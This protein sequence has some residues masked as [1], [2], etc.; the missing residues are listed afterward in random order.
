MLTRREFAVAIGAS[1]ALATLPAVAAEND[2]IK[3]GERNV[4]WAVDTDIIPVGAGMGSFDHIQLRVRGNGLFVYDLDV[5][6]GNGGNDDIPLQFHIP[7][8]GMTRMIDLRG[9]NRNIRH[10]KLTYQKPVDGG[11]PTW[12]ELWGQR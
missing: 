3:L 8:G 7:Q 1:A 10:V 6:Y 5:V 11:G 9:G 12:V 2:W 4:N